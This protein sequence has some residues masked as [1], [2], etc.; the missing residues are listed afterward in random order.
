[1]AALLNQ[2]E[3]IYAMGYMPEAEY[4]KRKAQILSSLPDEEKERAK[5]IF[6]IFD[7]DSDGKLSIKELGNLVVQ[8]GENF[9][10]EQ[11]QSAMNEIDKDQDGKLSFDEFYAWWKSQDEH[12]TEIAERL[13][14]LKMKLTSET[15]FK[16]IQSL[17]KSVRIDKSSYGT[18]TYRL[19]V[20]VN[21]GECNNTVAGLRVHYE[22]NE[23]K[24]NAIRKK[25]NCQNDPVLAVLNLVCTSAATTEALAPFVEL[26]DPLQKQFKKEGLQINSITGTLVEED[27]RKLW[28][29][30]ALP[31]PKTSPVVLGILGVVGIKQLDVEVHLSGDTLLEA[32]STINAEVSKSAATLL[33]RE[34]GKQ[35]P[36]QL[37]LLFSTF[38]NAATNLKFKGIGEGFSNTAFQD[39]LFKEFLE[40]RDTDPA[41][42]RGREAFIKLFGENNP[43]AFVTAL[44]TELFVIDREEKL[45]AL[46]KRAFHVF[47]GVHD[48]VLVAKDAIITVDFNFPHLK[49]YFASPDTIEEWRSQKMS[50]ESTGW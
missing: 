10:S 13:R 41:S 11:V 9:S 27:G 29:L 8:L 26:L 40:L 42:V 35:V 48:L 38:G 7:E 33:S 46:Y 34:K 23:E 47:T 1:M 21:F 28:R 20:S 43:T 25:S 50:S 22:K 24:A 49:S 39:F 31:K 12:Y 45:W 19:D 37:F 17:G 36:E 6:E 4:L 5:K 30:V 3:E 32:K 15:Y 44:L 16:H 14:F 2:L 18:E